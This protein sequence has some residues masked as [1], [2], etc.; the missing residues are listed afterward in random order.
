[1]TD[2]FEAVD[3]T[4]LEATSIPDLADAPKDIA[5]EVCGKDIA[6]LYKGKG[7]KPKY[8]EE[9]KPGRSASG[10][11]TPRTRAGSAGVKQAV[12]NLEN[13]YN[14][15]GMGLYMFGAKESASLLAQS[16]PGLSDQ[17]RQFLE[18]DPA[19]VKMLNKA[20]TAGGRTMFFVVNA[21]TIGPVIKLAYDEIAARREEPTE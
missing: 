17:N 14:M 15:L 20:G 16:V 7:R 6:Y 12:A 11:G 2:T 5:C 3:L 9:H 13:M 10:I 1:M 4:T 18:A 8:C 21:M 19:L